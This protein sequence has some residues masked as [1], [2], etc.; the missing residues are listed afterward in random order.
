MARRTLAAGGVAVVLVAAV[1]VAA[2]LVA[3]VAP[4][5]AAPSLWVNADPGDITHGEGE[6]S[7]GLFV[8][9][10]TEPTTV[11]VDLTPLAEA[12]VNLSAA[13][14]SIER[15]AEVPAT[16]RLDRT[17]EGVFARVQVEP[18]GDEPAAGTVVLQLK[19]LNTT[20]GA[21]TQLSYPVTYADERRSAQSFRLADPDLPWVGSLTEAEQLVTERANASQEVRIALAAVPASD[22]A[23]VRLNLSALAARNVSLA[24]ATVTARLTDPEDGVTLQRSRL[25]ET[26]VELQLTTARRTDLTVRLTLRG[27][28]TR[29]ARPAKGLRY[30]VT[31]DGAGGTTSDR[32]AS[33]GLYAPGETPTETPPPT[34]SPPPETADG[35]TDRPSG[36]GETP[37]PVTHTTAPGIG[38]VGAVL[39]VVAALVVGRC[40]RR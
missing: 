3:G 31:F 24:D 18:P 1:G 21:H 5:T 27:L 16:V 40:W 6:Q 33:F 38:V 20:D 22:G 7:I 13:T 25:T 30:T 4:T 14:A 35:A 8:E 37:R 39:A 36:D 19:G 9:G 17:D 23:T 28:D 34:T 12:G 32:T 29:G 2:M 11:T 15:G 26:G 10:V